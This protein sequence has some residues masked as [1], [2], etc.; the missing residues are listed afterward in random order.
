MAYP[1]GFD[2]DRWVDSTTGIHFFM[3]ADEALAY[4]KQ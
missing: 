4:M 3:T 1:S 2:E